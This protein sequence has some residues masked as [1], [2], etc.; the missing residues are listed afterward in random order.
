MAR[1]FPALRRALGMDRQRGS[2]DAR[3][4]SSPVGYVVPGQP[5]QND[6]NVHRA[7]TEG[8][9]QNPYIYRA[10]EFVASNERARRIV[11][12]DDDRITGTEIP[13]ADLSREQQ[14][15][16]RRLNRR[17]NEW[18][19]AQV[20]RHRLAAQFMLSARGVFVEAVRNRRGGVHSLFLLDPDRVEIVPGR[21]R[22][23]GQSA[24]SE[25]G[26]ISP[27]ESFR[28]TC[29]TPD[30]RYWDHRPPWNPH[31]T[32]QEQPS[33]IVWLR[34][35]HPTI[36]AQGTSPMQAAALSAD[37]DRH[38][39][40]Y[41]LL[42][43][44]E[45]GRPGT[46]VAVKGPISEPDLERI[47]Q[48]VTRTGPGGTLAIEA[49]EINVA[50][51]SGHPRDMQWSETM[52]QTASEFC[53][54]F[55]LPMSVVS[56]SAGQTFDNADA[57][58]AK[59]WEHAMLPLFSMLD[60]QLD[61]LTPGG[62]DDE[63]FLAHDVSDVWVLGRHQR[64]REDRAKADWD[65][66]LITVDEFREVCGLEPF[67]VPASRV[68][69]IPAGRLAVGDDHPAHDGDS[70]AAAK[71]PI[72]NGQAGG[73]MLGVPGALPPGFGAEPGELPAGQEP[74]LEEPENG[75]RRA[76]ARAGRTAPA[77]ELTARAGP[78]RKALGWEGEQRGARPPARR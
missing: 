17:A 45:D 71:A 22:K 16:L 19:I 43:M 58:Y 31:A 59:A 26:A 48:K 50:D 30:S 51:T 40:L 14:D 54:A 33:G 55:G 64:E 78:E 15:I 73:G 57:D 56:D 44:R 67:D 60:A 66:G 7:V 42:F 76:L 39:R 3:V 53:T 32:P 27:I 68:L 36:L 6:W 21:R 38:A 52:Q 9:G 12:R 24:P 70:E 28:I 37:L 8:Y 74:E 20:W 46:V 10:V 61:V 1:T 34:S 69:W 49:D 2:L 11:L 23:P 29:G 72:G 41:N 4:T 18:E 13:A 65:A 63:T 62:L 47:R 5:Y 25:L 75:G 77:D 35:P